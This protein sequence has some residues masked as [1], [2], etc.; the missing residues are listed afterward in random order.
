MGVL[1][2]VG[3]AYRRWPVAVGGIVMGCTAA[4][5]TYGLWTAAVGTRAMVAP[6]SAGQSASASLV[7]V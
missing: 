1:Y 4:L 2:L 6:G 3:M 5:T 7:S